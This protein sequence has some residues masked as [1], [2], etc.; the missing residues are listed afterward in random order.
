MSPEQMKFCSSVIIYGGILMDQNEEFSLK[1]SVMNCNVMNF[2]MVKYCSYTLPTV[3]VSNT[4]AQ[5]RKQFN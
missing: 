4:A 3:T 2:N 5:T 1:H